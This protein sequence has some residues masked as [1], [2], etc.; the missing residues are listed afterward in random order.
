MPATQPRWHPPAEQ[1]WQGTEKSLGK[2]QEDYLTD[3]R[4]K[5]AVT[6]YEK[7]VRSDPQCAAVEMALTLPI[8]AAKWSFEPADQSGLAKRICE[9]CEEVYFRAPPLGMTTTWQDHLREALLCLRYGYSVHEKVWWQHDGKWRYRKFASRSPRTIQAHPKGPWVWDKTG[10]VKAVRQ[11]QYTDLEGQREQETPIEDL[12]I[13]THKEEFGNPEGWSVFRPA[14]KPW[15]IKDRL[16][17]IMT[18]GFEKQAIP[19]L[20]GI[21]PPTGTTDEDRV[22][23]ENFIRSLRAHEEQGGAL[24]YGSEVVEVGGKFNGEQMVRGLDW[25]DSQIA[26]VVLAQFLQLGQQDVGTYSL[27]ED[28]T[29]FFLQALMSIVRYVISVHRYYALPELVR[30]NFGESAVVLAPTLICERLGS[31]NQKAF[32]ETLALLLN[33]K[34][35]TPDE[36]LEGRLREL[37][38]LPEKSKEIPNPVPPSPEAGA[39]VTTSPAAAPAEPPIETTGGNGEVKQASERVAL[40]DTPKWR[41]D[42]TPFER[43]VKFAELNRDFDT[44]EERWAAVL[45]GV[46][47]EEGATFAGALAAAVTKGDFQA[48][49]DASLSLR[50]K[51][52]ETMRGLMMDL[53]ERAK[54]AAAEELGLTDKPPTPR[55]TRAWVKTTA[56]SVADLH[57]AR[58]QAAGQRIAL[59]GIISGLPAEDVLV[60]VRGALAESIERETR[61]GA[62]ATVAPSI[63][64]GRDAAAREA[65]LQGMQFSAI[66]D[67]RT[68]P[69]CEQLDGMQIAEGDPAY[70]QYMPPLHDRCRCIWV[71][72]GKEEEGFEVTWEDP[73]EELVA[74]HGGLV[75]TR[76]GGE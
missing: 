11:W 17:R 52:A 59:K 74:A 66:L 72:I 30:V 40:T 67:D 47:E 60:N 49:S 24:P 13:F 73:S 31:R 3:L 9:F 41:R 44:S 7:M 70:E 19:F 21:Q 53:L 64:Y 33:A 43:K 26:R 38:E 12:L 37:L 50:G 57:A 16:I 62:E 46:A 27:S 28:Q 54:L 75:P 65:D 55:N 56:D 45:R 32:A 18:V 61:L 22:R 34:A 23:M 25:C 14:Y 1:G 5:E 4:G 20:L 29:T 6:V 2:V 15:L 68:C 63:N 69:L 35:V 51:Y 36:D 39:A 71:Y 48:V 10:G 42:L 8:T 76:G 58:W